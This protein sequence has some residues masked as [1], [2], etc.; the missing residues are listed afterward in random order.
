MGHTASG[1][2]GRRNCY[3]FEPIFSIMFIDSK[4]LSGDK[5]LYECVR[6]PLL[7]YLCTICIESAVNCATMTVRIAK[8]CGGSSR[9]WWSGCCC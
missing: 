3:H 2:G 7:P 1:G 4:R 9:S 5:Y 8:S 6:C